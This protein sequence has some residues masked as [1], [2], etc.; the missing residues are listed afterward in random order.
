MDIDAEVVGLKGKHGSSSSCFDIFILAQKRQEHIDV[1][2]IVLKDTKK[3]RDMLRKG[4]SFWK[5]KEQTWKRA[6][7]FPRYR[8]ELVIK[9]R[10]TGRPGGVYKC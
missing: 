8:E 5:G 7:G 3:C 6:L 2:P 1:V 9:R 4:I 10:G